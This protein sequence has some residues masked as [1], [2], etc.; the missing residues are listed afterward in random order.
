M[1][2]ILKV[3]KPEVV[4]EDSTPPEGSKLYEIELYLMSG[5]LLEFETINAFSSKEECVELL[6][7]IE[8][9]LRKLENRD[10]QIL[11]IKACCVDKVLHIKAYITGVSGFKT[12][13]EYL[14]NLSEV[15]EKK[16]WLRT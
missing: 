13:L 14:K 15:I 11:R 8:N 6:E 10:S 4:Y 5:Q 2:L 9:D 3:L 16:K 12:L 7:Y 1:L